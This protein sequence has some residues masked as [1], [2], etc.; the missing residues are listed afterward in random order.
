MQ[1]ADF[2]AG[3]FG[4]DFLHDDFASTRALRLD[5]VELQMVSELWQ[6]RDDPGLLEDYA[7]ARQQGALSNR[8]VAQPVDPPKAPSRMQPSEAQKLQ[9]A[10]MISP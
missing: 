5:K 4:L 6:M 2:V 3:W 9:P 7:L 10:S 8:P 1:L